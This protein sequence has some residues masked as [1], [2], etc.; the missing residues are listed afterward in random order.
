MCL[1]FLLTTLQDSVRT[2]PSEL[3]RGKLAPVS[4]ED[5]VVSQ[6]GLRTSRQD[7]RAGETERF[8]SVQA[9]GSEGPAPSASVERNEGVASLDVPGVL[10]P[11][12]LASLLEE[13]SS[14]PPCSSPPPLAPRLWGLPRQGTRRSRP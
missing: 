12:R 10:R 6:G 3:S 14:T 11:G 13:V 4:V 2:T 9:S 1:I 7:C 5:L 8:G